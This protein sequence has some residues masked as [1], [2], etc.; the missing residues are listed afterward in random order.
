[1]KGPGDFLN[2]SRLKS[3]IKVIVGKTFGYKP[4]SSETSRSKAVQKLND[5]LRKNR[6]KYYD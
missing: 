5:H 6:S 1:M 4:T 3:V 2:L